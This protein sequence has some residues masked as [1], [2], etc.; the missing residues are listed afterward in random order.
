MRVGFIWLTAPGDIRSHDAEALRLQV[1]QLPRDD[2]RRIAYLQSRACK[3][4]NTLF[5]TMPDSLAPSST[6]EFRSAVQNKAGAHQSA[7]RNLISNPI[8]SK[9]QATY[10]V[11]PS[12]YNLKKAQKLKNDGTRQDHDS[13]IN[14][15]SS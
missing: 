6:P 14:T 1:L 11:D 5:S 7:R 15:L 12:G 2:P 8:A 13:F 9:A 4:S 10:T 3:Y